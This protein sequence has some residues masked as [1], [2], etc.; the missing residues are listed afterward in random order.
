MTHETTQQCAE[1]RANK[2]N[3][4]RT[5]RETTHATARERGAARQVTRANG[6]KQH[7]STCPVRAQHAYGAR[8]DML[9]E[10]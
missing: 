7:S 1:R 6:A 4:V 3:S 5:A 8:A 9:R 10:T 2:Q